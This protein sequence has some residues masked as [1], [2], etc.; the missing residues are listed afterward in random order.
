MENSFWRTNIL[1][2]QFSAHKFMQANP[3]PQQDGDDSRNSDVFL[4]IF[5]NSDVFLKIARDPRNSDVFLRIAR[6][7]R[8]S[9]VFLKIACGP[10][11]S[12]HLRHFLNIYAYRLSF[13]QKKSSSNKILFS[14][15]FIALICYNF[16]ETVEVPPG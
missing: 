13:M 2:A 11:N 1:R 15:I 5:R 6:D 14:P 4:K 7:P 9:D 12:V 8:N 3:H 16:S 10:R